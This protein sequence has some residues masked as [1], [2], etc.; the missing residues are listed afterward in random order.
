MRVEDVRFLFEYDRWATTRILDVARGLPVTDWTDGNRIDRRG[1]GGI[2]LH[3]L[4]AHERWRSGWEG[5][6]R[7]PR[8]E[9]GPILS[10]DELASAWAAEWLAM[11]RYLGSLGDAALDGDFNDVTLWHTLVHLANHGTQHRSEAAAL[12]T[13]YGRSPGDLDLIFFAPRRSEG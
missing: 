11:D 3:A 9:E 8:R 10:P 13:A 12:L 2:L 6:D 5:L 4:G 1:L 7:P